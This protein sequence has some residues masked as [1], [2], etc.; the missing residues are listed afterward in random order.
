M[1]YSQYSISK[2]S[3]YRNI[4]MFTIFTTIQPCVDHSCT[5]L[6]V[7]RGFGVKNAWKRSYFYNFKNG[8]RF[9]GSS[10]FDNLDQTYIFLHLSKKTQNLRIC[11]HFG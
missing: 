8:K 10:L 4:E 6:L 9:W 3:H 2:Y 1:E 11:S 5:C 7:A